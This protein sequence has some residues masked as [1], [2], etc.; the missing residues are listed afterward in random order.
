LSQ[1]LLIFFLL[2]LCIISLG[3]GIKPLFR[4]TGFLFFLLGAIL[5][6]HL[7]SEKWGIGLN[8]TPERLKGASFAILRVCCLFAGGTLLYMSTPAPVLT[9]VLGRILSRVPFAKNLLHRLPTILF[10]S[11]DLASNL[12]H[13]FFLISK[14][15]FIRGARTKKTKLRKRVKDIRILLEAILLNS[16]RRSNQIAHSMA[17]RGLEQRSPRAHTRPFFLDYLITTFSILVP[18]VL[19]LTKL[20]GCSE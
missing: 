12:R 9:E 5:L 16:F 19:F 10:V 6:S 4:H 17:L 20:G 14:A 2:F 3:K 13:Q 8:P 18:L 15:Q 11:L 1:N 7:V